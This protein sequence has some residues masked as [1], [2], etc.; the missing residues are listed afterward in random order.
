VPGVYWE[1]HDGNY[2]WLPRVDD[3]IPVASGNAAFPDGVPTTDD[4]GILY[5]EGYI[6]VPV[7]GEYI[8]S[9]ESETRTFLRIHDARVLDADGYKGSRRIKASLLLRAG[10]HPFRRYCERKKGSPPL[11][12]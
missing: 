3:L 6:R 11:Q 10:W 7:D 4:D 1:R 2:P 12:L 8:F 5:Y 9:L